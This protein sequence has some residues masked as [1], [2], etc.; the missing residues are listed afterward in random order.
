MASLVERIEKLSMPE[1]NSG[2]W[3]WLGQLSYLGYG[4]IML[5]PGQRKTKAHRAAWEAFRGPIGKLHVLHRC[6]NRCCVNP[7]HL[8]LGT[9]SDNMLDMYSKGRHRTDFWIFNKR[10]Q[11]GA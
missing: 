4:Q 11:K 9:R 6:D 8:F 2:C 7:D 5:S 3:L 1:P 10:N